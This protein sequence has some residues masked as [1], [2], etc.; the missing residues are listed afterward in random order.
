MSCLIQSNVSSCS[1]GTIVCW[2]PMSLFSRSLVVVNID[3]GLSI[4]I[5]VEL[6]LVRQLWPGDEFSSE[7]PIGIIS[8]LQFS[9]Q[10]DVLDVLDGALWL[11]SSHIISGLD[12]IA[13]ILLSNNVLALLQSHIQLPGAAGIL[14][15]SSWVCWGCVVT[16][17]G[18][19]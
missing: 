9:L 13:Q 3:P 10:P 7:L 5:I 2:L 4:G 17:C 6:L 8:K 11:S 16:P 1:Q 12:N 15:T 14:S 18:M 19:T